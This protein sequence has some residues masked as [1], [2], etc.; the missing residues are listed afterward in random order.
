MTTDNVPRSF[1]LLIWF[2][3]H[4]ESGVLRPGKQCTY[5]QVKLSKKQRL[6]VSLGQ[7]WRQLRFKMIT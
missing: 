6:L 3:A 2:D 4:H 7:E 1:L 5:D